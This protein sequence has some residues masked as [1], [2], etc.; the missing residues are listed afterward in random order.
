MA[1]RKRKK[2]KDIVANWNETKE[3]QRFT[4]KRAKEI[5]NILVTYLR[6][7]PKSS[8][9]E[10]REATGFSVHNIMR[11]IKKRK[12]YGLTVWMLK[13]KRLWW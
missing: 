9:T 11:K 7:Y 8:T 6:K 2:R 1:R 13:P 10:I 12:R 5:D 4:K 3:Y